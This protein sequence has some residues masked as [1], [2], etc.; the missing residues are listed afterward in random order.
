M[1]PRPP[2]PQARP[3]QAVPTVV[4]DSVARAGRGLLILIVVIEALA[5]IVSQQLGVSRYLDKELRDTVHAAELLLVASFAILPI[6]AFAVWRTGR[7]R[8]AVALIR[9]YVIVIV[10]EIIED[11]FLLVIATQAQAPHSLWYLADLASVLA[12]NIAV[13]TIAYMIL[14]ATTSEEVF[15]FPAPSGKHAE[16]GLVDYLFLAFN[17]SMTFGPTIETPVDRRPK[18]VMMLQTVLSVT[19]LVVLASRIVARS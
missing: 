7:R 14:D 8:L 2:S 3:G 4:E 10:L 9:V 17:T 12:L 16:R 19:I 1:T 11:V 6:A 18:L 13:F 5:L 15:V